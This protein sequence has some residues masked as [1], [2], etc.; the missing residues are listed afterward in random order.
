MHVIRKVKIDFFVQFFRLGQLLV[1]GSSLSIQSIA[2]CISKEGVTK[3][4]ISISIET[5]RVEVSIVRIVD[6]SVDE[7]KRTIR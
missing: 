5:V 7:R 2:S 4:R 3:C 6:R 1:K